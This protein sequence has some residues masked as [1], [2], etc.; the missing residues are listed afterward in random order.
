MHAYW[1]LKSGE[2]IT[3]SYLD[4]DTVLDIKQFRQ[5][6]LFN[7]F[8]FNCLCTAC[9][10]SAS[11]TAA[12]DRRISEVWQRRKTWRRQLTEGRFG[13]DRHKTL[14]RLTESIQFLREEKI[15]DPLFELLAMQFRFCA[16]WAMMREAKAAAAE[17]ADYYAVTQGKDSAQAWQKL[18]DD[19][20]Q[21]EEW[22]VIVSTPISSH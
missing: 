2:E 7:G 18:V 14:K 11:E 15:Y 10:Q 22:G 4:P 3:A 6:I 21:A 19:P 12:S 5:R 13:L 17:A 8:A 16:G 20:S 9:T 1:D